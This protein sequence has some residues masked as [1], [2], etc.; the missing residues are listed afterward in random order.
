V[1]GKLSAEEANA[2][3]DS[4]PGW[5]I[6]TTIGRDGYPHTVPIGY[7]RIGDDI[8]LG[9]NHPTQKTRN[10]ERNP[11]VSLLVESG[12]SMRDIKGLMIQGDAELIT[13]PEERLRLAR[14]AARLRG[15]PEDQRPSEVQPGSA[16][17]RIAARHAISWDYAKSR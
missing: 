3:L 11:S 13:D 8:Y 14:E 15:V 17:I 2:F 10:I 5:I 1:P 16:Y 12:S 7:F 4:R 6:L 9:C